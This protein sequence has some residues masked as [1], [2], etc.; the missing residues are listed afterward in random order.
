MLGRKQPP[1]QI[2]G[3]TVGAVGRLLEQRD[4]LAGRVLHAPV[5]VD[6]AEQ[7]IAALLP[8]QWPFGRSDIAA[9]AGGELLDRLGGRNDLVELGRE[10]L[11]FPRWRLR[12]RATRERKPTGRAGCP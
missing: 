9:E 12:Q 1:L 8:P 6:V 5:A 7:E 3:E 2:A 10:L 11:D 4:A